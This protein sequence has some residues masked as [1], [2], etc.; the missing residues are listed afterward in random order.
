MTHRKSSLRAA[1]LAEAPT[2]RNGP[3]TIDAD[4]FLYRVFPLGDKPNYE[5]D[6]GA[7]VAGEFRVP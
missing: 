7:S 5:P 1:L 3:M 2:F 4:E 6:R